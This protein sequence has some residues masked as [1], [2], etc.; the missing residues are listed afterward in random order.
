MTGFIKK[1][2]NQLFRQ[3]PVK[4]ISPD[5]IP[6]IFIAGIS[7]D[8]RTVQPDHLFFAISGENSD[9]HAYIG[10]AIRRGAAAV[11]GTKVLL[12]L[13][14]PYIQ[15]EDGRQALA[16]F[17]AAFYDFPS[18]HMTMIGVTGTDGKTTTANL[19]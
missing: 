8:S 16:Y 6:D 5:E 7:F 1:T 13:P 14:I 12:D 2:L 3:I 4:V 9:G 10:E 19:I 17:S 11:V 18:R 15:V